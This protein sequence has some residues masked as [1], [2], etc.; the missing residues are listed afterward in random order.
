MTTVDILKEGNKQFSKPSSA[1]SA[2][3][4]L[5][6]DNVQFVLSDKLC[7]QPRTTYGKSHRKFRKISVESHL[8]TS[9][10]VVHYLIINKTVVGLGQPVSRRELDGQPGRY[11]CRSCRRKL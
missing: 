1:S 8:D 4:L 7:L 11:D 6:I 5:D 10:H 2:F 3:K 9:P